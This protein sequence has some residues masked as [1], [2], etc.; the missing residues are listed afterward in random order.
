[1]KKHVFGIIVALL[2]VC[3]FTVNADEVNNIES[4]Y[5]TLNGWVT[6]GDYTYY[7]VNGVKQ[8]NVQYID[9]KYYYFA[10]D[11]KMQYGVTDGT[12]YYGRA[13]GTRQYNYWWDQNG[14]GKNDYYFGSNGLK[15]TGVQYIDGK[16]YYFAEDGKMQYGVTDGT[17]YYG[18]DSGSRQYNYI[19]DEGF[20]GTYD[21][22]FGQDG[23]KVSNYWYDIDNDGKGDYYFGND[24]LSVDGVQKIDGKYYYFVNKLKQRGV[25]DG[26]Y[27]YGRDTGSRQYNYWW[28]VE[29]DGKADYYFENDGIKVTGVQYIEGKY[30]Y[31]A[32]D[33]KMQY[34]ATDGTYYYGRATGTRQYNYWWDVELDGKADYYFDNNGLKVTRV[35]YIEGK[36]YYFAED[37][38][39]QYGVTDGTYYYG[40]DTGSRQ[41]N[42]IWDVELDGSYDYYFGQNGKRV[43]NYWYDIDKDGKN[44]YYFGSDC[45]AVDGVQKIDGKYYYFINRVM[46]YG[47]TDG[48]YYYGRFTGAR[49]YSYWLDVERDGKADYYFNSEGLM[50][51]GV[52]YI[53]GNYYYFSDDG[54]KQYGATDGTYYYGRAT[55]TRQFDY[56][57]DENQDG[58]YDYYFGQDGKRVS[59]YWYDIDKDGKNDYYFGSD[60]LAVDGVQEIDGKY[61]YFINRVMQYG[62]TDG[63]YYYG[64]AT[65]TRQY[66]YWWDQN[67]DGKNDYYF[68]QDG[69]KV[70]GFQEIDSKHYYFAEDGKMQ[71]GVF[72]TLDGK[73]YY[74]GRAT[75]TRQ[76]GWI[77][78]NGNAYY[79]E[80][81][82]GVMVTGNKT[83]DG[84]NYVFNADGTLRD[85]FVT[86]TDGNTRYYFPDGSYA[87][88]WITIAGTK[89]FFN[90]LGV[91]I[92]K[93]VKK[94][95]D[96]SAHQG[97]IDWDTVISQGGVDGVILRIA[98]GCEQEDAMLARNIAELQRLGIPYGIYIYSYA[99]NYEE[100][101]LYANFTLEMIRKYNMN[102]TLGIYLD[103]ESNN[104][105]SYMG[106]YEYEQVTKGFMEVMNNNG[107]GSMTKIYTYKDYAD[108]VLN[109]DYLRSLIA[110]VAQYNH[111]CYYSGSYVGWQYSSTETVPGIAGNVDV[112]VW[113]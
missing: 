45:L 55:G 79:F 89:Y 82:S 70:T 42:Y 58:I 105:T 87:N 16:Y 73:T 100:G 39:K 76:Y 12:Y 72:K 15:V 49:Q 111:Y 33:G 67:F 37:G 84:V 30:Y 18:R 53:D 22:F 59:N 102:P 112:S 109:S 44:D 75:G 19:W 4:T 104:I 21:Y 2:I 97:Y 66:N 101:K 8:I 94:V 91:M 88:D 48:T 78:L 10:E 41:Y 20:D 96:V 69:R 92:G 36:Y 60:G 50:V 17:Y 77:F 7:Y 99:E 1:M 11:G 14:D 68:G 6:E 80:L 74:Y 43:S 32:E 5:S 27:Y 47:A 71:Y 90:S 54:K 28:D 64:R 31:F 61:Y 65:G 46:Q 24:Y 83:I 57:W 52:Q 3:P 110:W 95:I 98:A 86:D 25:T 85:G 29:L 51:T 107:Y 13:S 35:Q 93:N 9:G 56:I 26:T 108:T 113:F 34:G 63:T 106:T 23:K 38:K 81:D 62:A 103:L 40:R